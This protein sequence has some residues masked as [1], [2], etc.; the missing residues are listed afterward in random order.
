MVGSLSP[1]KSGYFSD[2]YAVSDNTFV[3]LLGRW[4]S[5]AWKQVFLSVFQTPSGH[6]A[7]LYIPLFGWGEGAHLV[8]VYFG[9]VCGSCT[10]FDGVGF[11]LWCR[12][13][14]NYV[15]MAASDT[16]YQV[17]GVPVSCS[18]M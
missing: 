18:V 15:L 2:A 4:T 12:S 13:N 5:S 3:G 16:N 6:F 10:V 7:G 14:K 9:S 11:V 1:L 8:G 17:N